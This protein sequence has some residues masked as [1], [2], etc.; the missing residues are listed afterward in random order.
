ML[1]NIQELLSEVNCVKLEDTKH[2]LETKTLTEIVEP[3]NL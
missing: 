1:R 2:E 3:V